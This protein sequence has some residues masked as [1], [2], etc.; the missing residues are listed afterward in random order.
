MMC[1]HIGTVGMARKEAQSDN[2]MSL[3]IKA[4]GRNISDR[5]MKNGINDIVD[6][7]TYHWGSGEF[8]HIAD[9]RK[10]VYT[11]YYTLDEHIGLM[12]GIVGQDTKQHARKLLGEIENPLFA[13]D[14]MN[15]EQIK[16]HLW[17]RS[18]KEFGDAIHTW[19]MN[20]NKKVL[21]QSVEIVKQFEQILEGVDLTTPEGFKRQ[22][23]CPS[24][25]N[26]LIF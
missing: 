25:W 11:V 1:H 17:E 4:T 22:C 21:A 19:E 12:R 16:S 5:H 9:I 13:I 7:R 15:Y 24:S 26:I 8:R 23:W 20:K 14:S 2:F 6:A 10:K 18:K 3:V